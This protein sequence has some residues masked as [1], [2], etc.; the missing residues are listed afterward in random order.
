M[1]ESMNSL[2]TEM[3]SAPRSI[4]QM[5]LVDPWSLYSFGFVVDQRKPMWNVRVTI[6]KLCLGLYNKQDVLNMEKVESRRN[7][8]WCTG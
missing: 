8:L 5:F 1:F 3:K 6:Q 7:V 4:V 2:K